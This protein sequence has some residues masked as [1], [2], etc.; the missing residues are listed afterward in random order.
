M[1]AQG[2][3]SLAVCMMSSDQECTQLSLPLK[4]SS[5]I[6]IMGLLLSA[7]M[8]YLCPECG[9]VY[10]TWFFL[11][12]FVYISSII[13]VGGLFPLTKGMGKVK[14]GTLHFIVICV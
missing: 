7:V 3:Q 5:I 2:V 10:A 9:Y 14:V 6:N 8:D 4:Y 1:A 12:T 13:P 11:Y